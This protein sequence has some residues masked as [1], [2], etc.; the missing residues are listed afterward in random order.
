EPSAAAGDA[1]PSP[2][3]P[4][5]GWNR[6]FYLRDPDDLVRLDPGMRIN[7][8][9]NATVG[10][11]VGAVAA[12]DGG[13]G[14]EPKVFLRRA[15]FELSGDFTRW[16]NFTMSMEFGGQPLTNSN[17]KTETAAGAAGMP[18]TADSARFAPV[19]LP[20]SS[21][22]PFDVW[23]NLHV[24]RE[25]NFMIGQAETPVS[26]EN[27][28]S[29]NLTL[30][31]ERNLAIR[32]FV[33][34]TQ[35]EL[36]VTVWGDVG[37]KGMF[38][39]EGG[40]YTGDGQNRGQVDDDADVIGRAFV[41][42]FFA[43]EDHVLRRLQIGASGRY[44]KRD[45]KYVG[46]DVSP[47]TTGQGYTLFGS[48]YKDSLGRTIHVIPS[49]AQ[50]VYGGELRVP[51]QRVALQAE[52]YYVGSDTREAVDGFQL[53]NTERLGAMKGVGW[54]AMLSAWPWGDPFIEGNPGYVRPASIDWEHPQG[55]DFLRGVEVVAIAAGVDATYDGASRGGAYDA[56]TP[57][58]PGVAKDIRAYQLGFGT[59]FWYS[60]YFRVMFNYMAYLTPGSGTRANLAVVP[61]NTVSTPVADAHVVHELGGRIALA[62]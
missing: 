53:A 12:P 24:V 62:F 20:A 30:L 57:G 61:G 26:M 48:T 13:N 56:K 42:P 32:G 2:V 22:V 4:L 46:Y 9:T 17:G 52:A 34:P 31:M 21:A 36:G 49:S 54:Y 29:D 15:R 6:Y 35:R 41:Q 45:P 60:R 43:N 39:Y 47:I 5:A 11:G 1:A 58:A 7:V 16:I 28:T 37:P 50:W 59:N 44:G 3:K 23:I 40:V 10:P 18:P 33:V 38:G 25:L 19:Q 8:D 27:R 51:I 55:P 14:L